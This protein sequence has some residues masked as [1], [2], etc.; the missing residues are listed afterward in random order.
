M[1]TFQAKKFIKLGTA[2]R[3]LNDVKY[4]MSEKYTEDEPL[5]GDHVLDNIKHVLNL[6]AE[7][8]LRG[9]LESGAYGK[10]RKLQNELTQVSRE[11]TSITL[12]QAERLYELARVLRGSLLSEG[13]NVIAYYL[14]D[15]EAKS[16]T[17]PDWPEKI[18]P[19][20][21]AKTPVK[22]WGWFIGLLAA[23]FILGITASET[24]LYGKIE[25]LLAS[26]Q[27]SVE[28][29][30]EGDEGAEGSAEVE[31]ATLHK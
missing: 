16:L 25:G 1:D 28:S 19:E 20:L 21:L 6:I 26:E 15:T 18:T 7:L 9:T 8:Q 13:N 11:A 27:P 10:L 3:Y 5:G 14:T 30:A 31:K 17:S 23:S 24:G 2:V 29:G 4:K 12:E 22:L